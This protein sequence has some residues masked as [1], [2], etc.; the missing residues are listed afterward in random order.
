MDFYERTGE[1]VAVLLPAAWEGMRPALTA[2]LDGLDPAAGPVVDVG[3]GTGL[4]TEVIARALPGVEILAV[5]PDR[6]LRTAL[7]SRIVTD[8]D[9]RAQVTVL[10]AAL[11]DAPLPDRIGAVVAMNVIGHFDAAGRARIWELLAERLA[12]GG[13]M[14]LNL[15]PPTRPEEV[16]ESA[17]SEVWV[18][19]RRYSGTAAARPAGPDSVIWEMGYHVEHDGKPVTDFRAADPWYVFTPEKLA[20]EVAAVGLHCRP[21]D[22]AAGIQVITR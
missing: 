14:V 16:P 13:R 2:A 4:G 8:P 7:L 22:P 17:M 3:A 9:L 6:A 18:G 20:A 21:G 5:E 19:R 10:D 12:P 15:Y 11:F 1:Y